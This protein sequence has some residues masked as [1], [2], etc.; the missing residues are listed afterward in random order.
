MY[1]FGDGTAFPLEENF[2][3]TLTQAVEAC[4][5][6]FS[7]LAELDVRREKALIAQRD[8]QRDVERLL[9]L[10]QAVGTALGP[11]VNGGGQVVQST[12]QKIVAATKQSVAVVRN[13]LEGRARA[14]LAEAEPRNVADLVQAAM[15][16]F[17]ERAELPGTTWV[18]SWDARGATALAEAVSTAGR[19]SAAFTLD[20]SGPWHQ[21]IRNEQ[22]ASEVIVHLVRKRTFGKAKPTPLDLGKMLMIS[23][24]Q[25]ARET[26]IGMRENAKTQAGYRFSLSE[27]GCTFSNLGPAGELEP[28][29]HVVTDEDLPSLRRLADAAISQL[30]G[31]RARR[32]VR[33]L[34]YG[35]EAL[36]Q[37][38][39]PKVFPLELLGQLTP[40][41]RALRDRSPV[42]GELVLKRDIGDG[43]RE[44]LFV[45]RAA[46]AARFQPL[47]A[48]YRRPFE[49]MGLG[50]DD[51]G[52]DKHSAA[53]GSAN[54]ARIVSSVPGVS[55]V[56]GP[57][58][59]T[60]QKIMG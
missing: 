24:E 17:F 38:P 33:D 16:P 41:C 28:E 44:E 10:D 32:T 30:A 52:G 47:P 19:L 58:A 29:V 45:P 11:F 8:S 20:L 53:Y 60:I 37:L 50:H 48:E 51:G 36:G 42:A 26:V 43:R 55:S 46:L 2:M 15:V 1:R 9:D 25:R 18:T 35:G 31:L 21:P 54:G 7:P 49:E 27:D 39:E 13:Q 40:L 3:D 5:H 59:P 23:I 6:A 57:N 22:F 12:A 14:M 4:T 56:A 34:R